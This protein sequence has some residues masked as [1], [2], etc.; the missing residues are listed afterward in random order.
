[1]RVKVERKIGDLVRSS[2]LCCVLGMAVESPLA[3][4]RREDFEEGEET[5][6]VVGS[7]LFAQVFEIK[8]ITL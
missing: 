1:M 6:K 5:L 4:G 7:A 8:A 3:V 2:V